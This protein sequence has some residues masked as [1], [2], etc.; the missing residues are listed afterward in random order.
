M[1]ICSANRPSTWRSNAPAYRRSWANL[2]LLE[3]MARRS[4]AL[5]ITRFRFSC[6]EHVTGT[7]NLAKRSGAHPL[8]QQL[9][10]SLPLERNA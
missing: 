3:G 8:P 6:E 7:S 5:D 4:R 9:L 1:T 2:V 10:L